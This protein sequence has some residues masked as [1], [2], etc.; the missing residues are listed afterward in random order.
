M[1]GVE[2]T[3]EAQ[4]S[5][6]RLVWALAAV[7]TLSMLIAAAVSFPHFGEK[8]AEAQAIITSILPPENTIFDFARGYN[9]PALSPDGRRIV[10]GARGADGKTQ[11]WLRSLDSSTAQPLAGAENAQFPFWSPDS[12]SIGFFAEGKLKRMDIAGGPALILAD[13]HL[14]RGGSWS[15]QGVIVFAPNISGPLQRVLADGGTPA[16]ATTLATNEVSHRFPSFLPDGRHFLFEAS[17]GIVPGPTLRMAALGSPETTSVGLPNTNGVYADGHLFYLRE[18]ILMAQPFDKKRLVTTGEAV[19]VAEQV[20]S[21]L[22]L[23]GSQGVFSVSG[24]GLL[25]YQ[26]GVAA[27]QQLTWFEHGGKLLGTF[28][29]GAGAAHPLH[30]QPGCGLGCHLVARR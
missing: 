20:P 16:T 26:Q 25:A 18:N 19:P 14:P 22:V 3:A 13:A 9:P 17:T 8:P 23:G 15:P 30:L 6:S 29:L 5:S 11:L 12:R 27:N 7:A 4:P 10:F 24:R 2:N 21:V 28:G 1:V